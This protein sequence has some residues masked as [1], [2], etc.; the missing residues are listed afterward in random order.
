M[1]HSQYVFCDAAAA[2]GLY[3]CFVV[4]WAEKFSRV[5]ATIGAADDDY[6]GFALLYDFGHVVGWSVGFGE[7][8][9]SGEGGGDSAIARYGVMDR[10]DR[11]MKMSFWTFEENTKLEFCSSG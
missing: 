9:V 1:E 11:E 7:F 5:A 10:W 6:E 3:D 4:L 8:G 2:I